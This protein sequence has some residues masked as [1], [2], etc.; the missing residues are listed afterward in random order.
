VGRL[1]DRRS[2]PLLYEGLLALS[3]EKAEAAVFALARIGGA[4]VR[5]TL[6]DMK[7]RETG[8][9]W[10]RIIRVLYA[11]GDNQAKQ[12]LIE[13]TLRQPAYQK[14]AAIL[15]AQDG[16]LE[17]VEWLRDY[18]D[19]SE[20]PNRENLVYRAQVGVA[21]WEIGDLQAR[22]VLQELLDTQPR[23]VYARGRTSDQEYKQQVAQ[24]VRQA[25][26]AQIGDTMDRRLL[27]LLQA[28]VE[29]QNRETALAA[30]S[31]VMQIAN[32]D[33]GERLKRARE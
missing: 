14:T 10:F 29:S 23:N 12:L 9:E 7:D 16:V 31:A 18:L 20:N 22:T 11:L 19:T 26:C 30:C 5:Q 6:L 13:D 25:T 32:K 15:L 27:R 28:P 3:D 1:G 2:L 17:G 33:F 4:D 24:T 8:M 21:L